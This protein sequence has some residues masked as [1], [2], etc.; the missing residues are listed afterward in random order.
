MLTP[1]AGA[2]PSCVVFH[3]MH[4][5]AGSTFVQVFSMANDAVGGERYDCDNED[6]HWGSKLCP[7]AASEQANRTEPRLLCKGHALSMAQSAPWLRP[8]CKWVTAFREPVSRL[9]SAYYHCKNRPGDPLCGSK[10]FDFDS[11]AFGNASHVAAFAAHW[12]DFAFR[13]MLLH[14]GLREVAVPSLSPSFS[15]DT[16]VWWAWKRAIASTPRSSVETAFGAVRVALKSGRLFDV[17]G[18]VERF[19]DTCRL[20]DA[21]LPLPVAL[22]AT[23]G[24]RGYADAAARLTNTHK[25]AK[26]KDQEIASLSAASMDPAV[27]SYLAWDLKLYTEEVLPLFDRQMQEAG[28]ASVPPPPPPPPPPPASPLTDV[29]R[30]PSDTLPIFIRIGSMSEESEWRRSLAR[31]TYLRALMPL[32]DYVYVAQNA[33]LAE[34]SAHGDVVLIPRSLLLRCGT[35]SSAKSCRSGLT[36]A[37]GLEWAHSHTNRSYILSVDDDGFLCTP[38]L[39]RLVAQLPAASAGVVVGSW[40]S[41]LQPDQQFL[42]LSRDV[43]AAAASQHLQALKSSHTRETLTTHLGKYL[44]SRPQPL[45]AR[46]AVL[47]PAHNPLALWYQRPTAKAAAAFCAQHVW[48]H[49]CCIMMASKDTQTERTWHAMQAGAEKAA[50]EDRSSFPL[51]RVGSVGWD[52]LPG[53]AVSLSKNGLNTSKALDRCGTLS[54]RGCKESF[55]NCSKLAGPLASDSSCARELTS[56]MCIKNSSTPPR[57]VF[58]HLEKA[59]GRYVIDKL[60]GALGPNGFDIV[61]EHSAFNRVQLGTNHFRIGVVREP[62]DYYVSEYLW[63]LTGRAESGVAGLG[64]HNETTVAFDHP[65][66]WLAFALAAQGNAA[67]Y[68]SPSSPTAFAAWLE[69]V[70]RH[71]EGERCGLLS[72]RLWTQVVRPEA[73]HAINRPGCLQ[74]REAQLSGNGCACPLADCAGAASAADHAACRQDLRATNVSALFDCWLR[75]SNVDADL[76]ACLHQYRQ[77]GGHCFVQAPTSGQKANAYHANPHAGC[78]HFHTLETAAAIERVDGLFTE[79]FGFDAC[80][81]ARAWP[82]LRAWPMPSRTP[83]GYAHRNSLLATPVSRPTVQ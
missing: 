44:S 34:R 78:E 52:Y 68:N 60:K 13:E 23:Y 14:P 42:L 5:S 79:Q 65:R 62:C 33:S 54:C 50:H 56:A 32:S 25:S 75:L 19:A 2:W 74:T 70:T 77:R 7:T 6:W 39:S 17:V 47:H 71:R 73:L 43:A 24:Y 45:D 8:P 76:A 59:G 37:F 35:S 49:M 22:Q 40:H 66:G 27:R 81:S 21:V 69:H 67:L 55:S 51:T 82:M 10:H 20:L 36:L 30:L 61:N 9:L 29:R 58:W 72:M 46:R 18:V 3:A 31:A 15:E 53:A 41:N 38:Q 83:P 4:K 26:W 48:I 63:G 16:Y 80:C 1:I 28:L 11:A 57:V 12:G 64:P